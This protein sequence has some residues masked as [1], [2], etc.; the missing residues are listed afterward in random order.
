[1]QLRQHHLRNL[2]TSLP[3]PYTAAVPRHVPAPVRS[4]ALT[5]DILVLSGVSRET[6]RTPVHVSTPCPQL[7]SPLSLPACVSAECLVYR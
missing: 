3:S 1:M 4:S 5:L 7:N 6:G 2:T